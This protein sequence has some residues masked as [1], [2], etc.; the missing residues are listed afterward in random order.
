MMYLHEAATTIL[1][2]HVSMDSFLKRGKS[3]PICQDF[4]LTHPKLNAVI[5]SDG[6]STA[7]MTDFGSRILCS[8][9]LTFLHEKRMEV[10]RYEP[11]HARMGEWII[12][13][14]SL[15]TKV[16]GISKQ[17]LDATLIVAYRIDDK[18]H[19]YMYGDGGVIL[20][21]N[22]GEVTFFD[23]KLDPNAP[24]YLSYDL[25]HARMLEYLRLRVEKKIVAEKK[26]GIEEQPLTSASFPVKMEVSLYEYPTVLITSDGITSF[27]HLGDTLYDVIGDLV[28]FKTTNPKARFLFRRAR[29]VIKTLEKCG[30]VHTD[31]I[32]IGGF[33]LRKDES[34]D[35]KLEVKEEST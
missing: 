27:E 20:V 13:R 1:N 3:H 9:A 10:A 16:L 28:K 6:C 15:V 8:L 21:D 22:K 24:H 12:N 25:D 31:D 14:A 2:E 7:P 29:K 23:T 18:I 11:D 19:I 5:L 4:I 30:A 33:R 17:C 32:S 35:I 34:C 26:D